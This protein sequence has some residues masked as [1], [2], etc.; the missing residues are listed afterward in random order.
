MILQALTNYYNLMVENGQLPEQGYSKAKVSF[1]LNINESGDLIGIIPLQVPTRVGKKTVYKP[2]EMEVPE[3]ITRTVN[4]G[5]NFL[6][7]N[8]GY[9]LGI[10]KKDNPTRT[11][12]CFNLFQDLHRRVLEGVETPCA[13]AVLAFIDK[14]VPEDQKESPVL[15]EYLEPQIGRART[16]F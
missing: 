11:K 1:A 13:R 2:Q 12:E 10:D 6:C 14:W 16:C 9:V 4:T 15:K 7:D 3:Q 8:S 5:S